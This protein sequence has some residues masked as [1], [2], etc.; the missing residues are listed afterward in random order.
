[1]TTSK[2]EQLDQQSSYIPGEPLI[3]ER[4]NG[5]VYARYRD[6]PDIPRW[7]I[8]GEPNAVARAEGKL[9]HWG[10]W[11]KLCDLATEHPALKSQLDKTINLY[12]LLKDET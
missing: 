1:M 11:E 7:I 4:V 12:Y 3:Y 2:D 9:L 8:G 6:V 10:E 5:V